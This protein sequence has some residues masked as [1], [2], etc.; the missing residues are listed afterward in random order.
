M[1]LLFN[2][3]SFTPVSNSCLAAVDPVWGIGWP[4]TERDSE[5]TQNCPP[6]LGHTITGKQAR[7]QLNY[8]SNKNIDNVMLLGMARETTQKYMNKKMALV[9]AFMKSQ[10][11]LFANFMGHV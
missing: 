2:Y 7:C 5:S 8:T 4:S 6:H 9:Q 1:L 11:V 3:S 10:N